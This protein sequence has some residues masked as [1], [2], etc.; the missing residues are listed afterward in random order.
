MMIYWAMF[1][2]SKISDLARF[3]TTLALLLPR[4]ISLYV[5]YYRLYLCN[6]NA[7]EIGTKIL[8]QSSFPP[9]PHS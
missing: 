2:C 5:T 1:S 8:R 6:S 7:S 9:L 3:E 4:N